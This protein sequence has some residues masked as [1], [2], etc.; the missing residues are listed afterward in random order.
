MIWEKSLSI[1]TVRQ[2]YRLRQ[3]SQAKLLQRD[4]SN[5]AWIPKRMRTPPL[6]CHAHPVGQH[7]ERLRGEWGRLS[8]WPLRRT[9]TKE[10]FIAAPAGPDRG[11]HAVAEKSESV[12]PRTL[13]ACSKSSR[14]NYKK[15]RVE[16]R[17][18]FPLSGGISPLE[19]KKR[20]GSSP[21]IC[22]FL[23]R[24]PGVV[25]RSPRTCGAHDMRGPHRATI[26][27]A[28]QRTNVS[29][30]CPRSED[31]SSQVFWL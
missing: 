12:V 13:D 24:E 16:K 2:I 26:Q 9:S 17:K 25:H 22:R 3:S 30:R 10:R 19:N 20:L 18:G 7:L 31:R 27:S 6:V 11:K 29:S 28:V 21:R 15:P 23:V 5:V 4:H 8:T 1:E 14:N